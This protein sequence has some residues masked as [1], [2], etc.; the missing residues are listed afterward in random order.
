MFTSVTTMENVANSQQ[1][2][3]K[4]VIIHNDKVNKNYTLQTLNS[5]APFNLLPYILLLFITVQLTQLT[6][7]H[8]NCMTSEN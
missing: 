7:R 3:H 8:I 6:K 5:G 4:V 2:V 1:Q